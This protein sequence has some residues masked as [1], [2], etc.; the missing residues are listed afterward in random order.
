MHCTVLTTA[1]GEARAAPGT[2]VV[3]E[4]VFKPV[5]SRSI[6]KRN[7]NITSTLDTINAIPMYEY[8]ATRADKQH[9]IPNNRESNYSNLSKAAN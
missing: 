9:R 6:K 8:T 1:T 5:F 3:R 7:K 2:D 4:R